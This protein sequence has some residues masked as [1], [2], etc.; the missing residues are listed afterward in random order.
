MRVGSSPHVRGAHL[1]RRLP[2]RES[3]II[4][5]CAGSTWPA[6]PPWH[7]SWDHPRM[8]GEHRNIIAC[9]C[10][11]LGSSPHVRGAQK[12]CRHRRGVPGIIPACAGSTIR[13]YP[14]CG[15]NGDHPR[16]CGEHSLSINH[17]G[18]PVGS[19]PH[20]RGA[21]LR[22]RGAVGI[23]R[24]IPA[25]AGSTCWWRCCCPCWWD[26][27]RMCGEHSLTRK[28]SMTR[29]G[30]SPHVRGA[31]RRCSFVL[32]TKKGSSPHVRGA[33][34][35]CRHRRG[36]P[37]IIPA[38]AGSTIRFYP[39]CGGNGDHP[40]MCGEHSLSINH[41]GTPVGSSPHVRGAPLRK[42]GAVGIRRIIPA[43]AG[44]TC[45]WRCCCPCWWDHPRMCGEHSLTRKRSMTRPGSSPHVRGAHR[46]CS[47]V[48]ETKKGSSPHVRGALSFSNWRLV[49]RGIIPACAGST[50]R[51]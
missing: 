2:R 9:I 38:C 28:R 41:A 17:A 14:E 45:W 39:E 6:S 51:K 3:G 26:H 27:P 33:Q 15:G 47:F 46:R 25:C 36:V 8:C 40:R 10:V 18:T 31:H 48:L 35:H 34:K 50:L 30:S 37:G 22:K 49:L 42:R 12:H 44:S 13:F 19:S 24:I 23:R 43:C 1:D 5:A 21:P 20:V 32:E 7:S 4:P 11:S 16:M 29:P